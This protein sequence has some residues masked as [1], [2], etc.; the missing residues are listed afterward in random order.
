M[1]S[2]TYSPELRFH[3]VV[4]RRHVHRLAINAPATIR[5]GWMKTWARTFFG[6]PGTNG[7]P[8]AGGWPAF[9]D[10]QLHGHRHAGQFDGI[11]R[12]KDWQYEIVG[13]ASW[14]KK[15]PHHPLRRRHERIALNHYEATS[16]PGVSTSQAAQR[17]SMA[18][19][20][21]INS[22]VSRSSFWG[23]CKL[24][25]ER[26]IAVR[27]KSIDQP[28]ERPTVFTSRMVGKLV[29]TLPSRRG[30]VGISSRWALERAL[31][32]GAMISTPMCFRFVVR[33]VSCPDCG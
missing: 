30:C 11:L 19:L 17:R 5:C 2:S 13:N 16:G 26:G 22:T 28:P 4:C 3:A 18:G 29:A 7:A 33:A 32:L 31:G 15:I 12:Y 24:G 10:Y 6:I 14:T 20:P 27:R 9:L 23:M 21:Q 25:R 1:Y 8:L